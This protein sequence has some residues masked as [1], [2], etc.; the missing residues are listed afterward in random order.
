[1]IYVVIVILILILLFLSY[2]YYVL[3]NTLKKKNNELHSSLDST[4]QKVQV[5]KEFISSFSKELRTPLYGI[6]G[7]ANIL[8][9][10]HPELKNNKNLKSL[11]FS[12]DYLLNLINNIL[13]VNV[14][15][16]EK[17]ILD[18]KTFNLR[19]LTQNIVHSFSYATENSDNT[20]HL[21]LE[22]DVPEIVD[23]N[24]AILAQILMNLI[25]N[26]LRFTKNG[27]IVF[28]V[29]SMNKKDAV[30]TIC[31]KVTHDGNEVSKEDEKSIYQEFINIDEIKKSY[32]GTGLNSSIVNRLAK[33][34]QGEI[35]VQNNA[36]EGSEYLLVIDLEK[37][38]PDKKAT[39]IIK[40]DRQKIL[41]V[42]DNKL[43]LLVADKILTK[44][45]FVCTT[46]DNGFDAI[47]LAKEHSY[48]L[49]LMDINMPKLNGIGT[50]K[51]IRKFNDHTPIIALTGVDV[52][53][54]NRQIIQ[55]GLNDYL[56][57]PYDKNA[58]LEMI[59]KHIA[60]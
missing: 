8:S 29:Q 33:S 54:L 44:E 21:D 30:H 38:N 40:K 24:P 2:K 31:F 4:G 23:G 26:A 55:A 5:N 17:I 43:N 19:E 20:L 15:E 47:E 36:Q 34:L 58:L 37:S 49:I 25:S 11:K 57:K 7:L 46:I 13:Q 41:I 52:T 27:N 16:S 10:E 59:D 9:D 12:G 28:S 3:A 22:E 51:R 32:L 18:K 56:L 39:N 42:D 48:D 53:Q 45:N 50:T 14:L 6:M 60:N 35:I 1:M